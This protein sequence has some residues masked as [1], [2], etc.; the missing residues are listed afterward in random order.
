MDGYHQRFLAI[1]PIHV[2]II[3]LGF[4]GLDFRGY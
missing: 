3:I 1:D 2:K 4:V